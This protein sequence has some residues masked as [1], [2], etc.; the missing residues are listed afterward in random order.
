MLP[1]AR[2]L[3]DHQVAVK[4][5]QA[6]LHFT[7]S[8]NCGTHAVLLQIGRLLYRTTKELE[9][10]LFIAVATPMNYWSLTVAPGVFL[11]FFFINIL[12]FSG[13]DDIYGEPIFIRT[14]GP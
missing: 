7:E 5:D 6:G 14:Y 13:Y 2:A 9:K 8:K 3:L 12:R 1:L 4:S 10:I 11:N